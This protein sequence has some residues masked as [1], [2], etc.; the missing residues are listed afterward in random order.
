MG[1]HFERPVYNIRS[2]VVSKAH[3]YV[4]RSNMCMFQN[5]LMPKLS[6]IELP[7]FPLC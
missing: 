1:K 4:M 3:E 2:V 6:V 7:I 5:V